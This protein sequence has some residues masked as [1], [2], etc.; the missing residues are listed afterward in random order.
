LLES[1]RTTDPP[2]DPDT[3]R[4]VPT[5]DDD[6]ADGTLAGGVVAMIGDPMAAERPPTVATP[7]TGGPDEDML[8]W[9]ASDGAHPSP[10][11]LPPDAPSSL[12]LIVLLQDRA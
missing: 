9:P 4:D 6:P 7:T 11:P 2:A 12:A 10:L 3:D 5:L 8:P 1:H